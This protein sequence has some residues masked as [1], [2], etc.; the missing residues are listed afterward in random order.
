MKTPLLDTDTISF[1]LKG[2]AAVIRQMND[3][4]IKGM[5]FDFF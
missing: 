1:F 4:Y 5:R 2:N 3:T